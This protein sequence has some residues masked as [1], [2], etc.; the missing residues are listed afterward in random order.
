MSILF[1]HHRPP[2]AGYQS[3]ESLDALLVLAAFGQTPHLLFQGDGVWQ[4][5]G[6]HQGKAFGYA[7]LSAQLQALP[8]YDIEEIHVDAR[9]LAQR[10][11]DASQLALPVTVLAPEQLADFIRQHRCLIRL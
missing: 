3:Q 7:A 2:H 6:R 10:G 9:S 1:I 8:L 5:Y 4:L 11:L